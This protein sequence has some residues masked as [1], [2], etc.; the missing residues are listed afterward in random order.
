MVLKHPQYF[1]DEKEIWFYAHTLV[2]EV[3]CGAN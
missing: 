2:N 3:G 1:H